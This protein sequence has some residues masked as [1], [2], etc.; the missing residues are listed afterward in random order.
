MKAI[1]LKSGDVVNSLIY[2]DSK[3]CMKVFLNMVRENFGL[4]W[5]FIDSDSE[6]EEYRDE[7]P[8]EYGINIKYKG[9]GLYDICT[10]LKKKGYELSSKEECL[11]LDLIDYTEIEKSKKTIQIINLSLEFDLANIIYN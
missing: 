6:F 7:L 10:L 9:V 2:D 4:R 5:I 11:G 3:Q 1:I 8:I